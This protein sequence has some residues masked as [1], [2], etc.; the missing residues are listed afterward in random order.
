[1]EKESALNAREFVN[2]VL[3]AALEMMKSKTRGLRCVLGFHLLGEGGGH[4]T[5]RIQDNEVRLEEGVTDYLDCV[6]SIP[7]QDYLALAQGTLTPYEAVS[8]G[9]IGI[10][11]NLGLA[12]RLRSLFRV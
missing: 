12:S 7:A 1:M 11:G 6:I 4:W 9:K 5:I 3:P 10:S 2:Q 8:K